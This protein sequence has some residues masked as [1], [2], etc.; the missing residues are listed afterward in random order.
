MEINECSYLVERNDFRFLYYNTE[1]NM[2][3]DQNGILIINIFELITPNDLL[4]FRQDPGHCIFQYKNKD[5]ILYEIFTD[6]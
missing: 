4:L 3:Y 5:N 1:Q 2:F 6:E